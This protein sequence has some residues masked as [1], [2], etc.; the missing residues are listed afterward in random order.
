[1]P[2]A[3][4]TA[5]WQRYQKYLSR[6]PAL[7]LTL[8]VSRMNFDDAFLDRMRPALEVAFA[9]MTAL[10]AGAVANPDENRMVGHYWLRAP[11][12]APTREIAAEIRETVGYVKSFA[13][14]VHAQPASVVTPTEPVPPAAA[15]D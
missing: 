11:D 4:P 3:D 9:G 15:I 5:L 7:G 14:A 1:M 6:I 10:E 2:A 8:D 13:A 12:L